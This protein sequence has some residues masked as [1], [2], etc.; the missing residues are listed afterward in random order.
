MTLCQLFVGLTLCV[1]IV[2]GSFVAYHD[3]RIKQLEDDNK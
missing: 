1:V 3:A 2:L